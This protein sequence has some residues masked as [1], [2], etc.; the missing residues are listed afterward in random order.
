MRK[1]RLTFE[2]E[3]GAAPRLDSWSAPD[4]LRRAV[5]LDRD[6]AEALCARIDRT[7]PDLGDGVRESRFRAPTLDLLRRAAADL[8]RPVPIP[9][10]DG[11]EDAAVTLSVA[12]RDA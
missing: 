7:Y 4:L 5:R 6:A 8:G 2:L 9:A 12:W 3:H 1:T 11:W 10:P